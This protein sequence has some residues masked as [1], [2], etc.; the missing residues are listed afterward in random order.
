MFIFLL[1]II[2]GIFTKIT[3]HGIKL[4]DSQYFT[5][6]TLFMQKMQNLTISSPKSNY[7]ANFPEKCEFS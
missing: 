1:L 4:L 2:Q 3:K 5:L 6:L 7:L